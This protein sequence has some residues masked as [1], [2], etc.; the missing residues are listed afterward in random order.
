[1]F[2]AGISVLDPTVEGQEA[3]TSATQ[4]NISDMAGDYYFPS[5]ALKFQPTNKFSFGILYDQPFGADAEYT[6][7]NVFVSDSTNTILGQST[8]D[9]LASQTVT[10]TL[11]ANGITTQAITSSP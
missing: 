7:D 8:L 10:N 11:A 4:R 3:G 9:S 2:E 1:Y 5:A 6:G